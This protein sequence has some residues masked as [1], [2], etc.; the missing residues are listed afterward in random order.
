MF[1]SEQ[2]KYDQYST[3]LLYYSCKNRQELLSR[4]L[5][6]LHT[7]SSVNGC[8]TMD[9]DILSLMGKKG[10]ANIYFIP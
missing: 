1:H 3:T 8:Y 5:G 9:T 6:H 2:A 4:R 7:N 10:I